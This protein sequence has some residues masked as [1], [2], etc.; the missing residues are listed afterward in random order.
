MT[1]ELERMM[2]EIEMETAH[3]RGLTGIDN[4]DGRVLAA[5]RQVP[6]HEFVPEELRDFA[7]RNRPQPIG[8]GQTISQPFIVAL[9]TDLLRAGPDDTILEIGA[10]SGYQAAVLSKLV[11]K[12]Y[13]IEVV[14]KLAAK[15]RKLLKELEYGNIVIREGNGYFGWEEHAPYA[16]II[17]TAAAPH[18]PQALIEQ[19]RPGGRLVIPVGDPGCYQELQVIEKQANGDIDRQTVLGV[20]FVPLIVPRDGDLT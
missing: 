9:M 12:V 1:N 20:S 11:A 10:G 14:E 4:L 5:M 13:S 7:Y 8:S 18:V 16:G 3:T 15:A 2:A 17:V 6:R 19:L